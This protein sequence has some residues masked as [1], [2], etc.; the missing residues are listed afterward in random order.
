LGCQKFRHVRRHRHVNGVT[1]MKTYQDFN[2]EIEKVVWTKYKI[3][4][5]TE[6]DKKEVQSALEHCHDSRDIDTDFVTVNQLV[7]EYEHH[8]ESDKYSNIIVSKEMYDKLNS[9]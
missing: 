9:P 1:N 3:V 7:H 6:E 2:D 8:D 5:P 4:V